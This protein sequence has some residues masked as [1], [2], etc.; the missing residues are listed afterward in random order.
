MNAC[1][2]KRAA[3]VIIVRMNKLC[4]FTMVADSSI[5]TEDKIT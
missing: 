1:G 4:I 3:E 2:Y 5:Y